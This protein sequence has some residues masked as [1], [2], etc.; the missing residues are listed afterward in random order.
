MTPDHNYDYSMG[1]R[2]EGRANI[3]TEMAKRRR[4]TV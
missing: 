3:M 1:G 2:E 4:L